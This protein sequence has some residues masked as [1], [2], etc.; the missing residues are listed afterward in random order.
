MDAAGNAYVTGTTLSTEATFPVIVG[1]DPATA[2]VA[3]RQSALEGVAPRQSALED[4][5]GDG[6]MDLILHFRTPALHSAGLLVDGNTL[7]LTGTLLDGTPIVGL[8]VIFLVGGPH[9]S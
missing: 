6:T 1:P 3:P 2:G 4:V 8:D 7:F 9:C 5:D